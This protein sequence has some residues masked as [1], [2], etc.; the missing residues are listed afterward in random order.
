MHATGTKKMDRALWRRTKHRSKQ[1]CRAR[2][3]IP[4]GHRQVRD[5]LGPSQC[6]RELSAI[7]GRT[8]SHS[9]LKSHRTRERHTDIREEQL[10]RTSLRMKNVRTIIRRSSTTSG[11]QNSRTPSQKKVLYSEDSTITEQNNAFAS[12]TSILWH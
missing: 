12:P 6:E 3:K 5:M 11:T 8:L 4:H 1:R 2:S 10:N 7:L 9:Y